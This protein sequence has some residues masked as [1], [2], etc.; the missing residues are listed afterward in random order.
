MKEKKVLVSGCY[1]LIHGGHVAFFKTAAQYGKLYVAVGTDSNLLLLKGK[2]PYY[3]Q[4]ERVFMVN[5]FR[6]VEK[7]FLAAGSGMLDF[8]PDMKRIKP[9]IFIVNS[10]GHT[11]EKETLCRKFG[12]EYKVLERIPEKG[13]PQRASSSIKKELQ[14]PYRICI[15]GGWMDQPWVSEIYPGSVVVAQIWPTIEFNDRSGMATSSRKVALDIW[16]NRY[17][18]GDPEKNAQLLFGAENPPGTKHVSG[19]QDHL[20]LLCPGINRLLYEGSYWPQ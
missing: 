7:A 11:V 17:P 9:D 18:D 12:V 1:D 3:S 8:E 16:G 2:A 10:D 19:S 5:S 6:F 20:G 15:A 14:F 4:E 13:L